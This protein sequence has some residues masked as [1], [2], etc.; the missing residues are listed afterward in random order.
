MDLYE[1]TPADARR[2]RVYGRR[3]RRV[4]DRLRASRC[5]LTQSDVDS[6]AR[7]IMRYAGHP[8]RH[9]VLEAYR[10]ALRNYARVGYPGPFRV[11]GCLVCVDAQAIMTR[12]G[13]EC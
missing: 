10:E 9:D 2:L 1:F 13:V 8:D 3:L 12:D 6:I 7:V 4:C 11:V 5:L